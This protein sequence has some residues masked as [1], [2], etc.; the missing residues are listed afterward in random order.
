MT[1]LQLV[2]IIYPIIAFIAM[3]MIS[4]HKKE[5]FLVFLIVEVCMVY[6]GIKSEQYGVC[7][8]AVIYFLSNIYGYKKWSR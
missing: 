1:L 8:M 4:H 6:I 3:M 7:T 5:G 2:N